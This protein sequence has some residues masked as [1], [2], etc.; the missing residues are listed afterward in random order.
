MDD[1][2]TSVME[3]RWLLAVPASLILTVLFAGFWLT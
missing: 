3:A 1:R 2:N